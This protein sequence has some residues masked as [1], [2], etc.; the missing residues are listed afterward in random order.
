MMEEP[1]TSAEDYRARMEVLRT[2]INEERARIESTRMRRV[3]AA[4]MD[5]GDVDLF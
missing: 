2:K 5:S 4:S 3:M 1:M